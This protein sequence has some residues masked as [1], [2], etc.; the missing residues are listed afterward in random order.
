[1]IATHRRWVGS[2]IEIN[3]KVGYRLL[4]KFGT[5]GSINLVSGIPLVGGGVG[6]GVN[7]VA[8]NQIVNA[9]RELSFRW[10]SQPIA[11]APRTR[12][13]VDSYRRRSL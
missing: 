10:T 9:P 11:P 3:K 12:R 4:T 8:I 7:V 1:L 13:I 6:A 2:L 5:K